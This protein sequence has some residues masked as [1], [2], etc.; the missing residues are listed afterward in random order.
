MISF[1]TAVLILTTIIIVA[2]TIINI[3]IVAILN[4]STRSNFYEFVIQNFSS[5]PLAHLEKTDEK[6]S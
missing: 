4:R 2:I 1:S 3:T 6:Y 5:P